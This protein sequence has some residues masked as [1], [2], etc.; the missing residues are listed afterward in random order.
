MS[1]ILITGANGQLGF[2]LRR[3]L[4]PLGEVFA[5]NREKFDLTNKAAMLAAL[6]ALR[7]QIVVNP[8]GY[9]AVDHAESEGPLAHAIN[10]HAPGVLA[11]WCAAND[12]LLIHYSTD[13][14]F[15]GTGNRAWT[16]DD[17]PEPMSVYANSKWR[18]EQTV[19]AH[20]GHHLILRTSWV[21]GSHGHNFLKTMLRLAA[22]RD[23]LSVVA[24]QI[25]APTS[26]ALIAD[27]TAQLITHYR[28]PSHRFEYGTYHLAAQGETSWHGYACHAIAHAQRL[29]YPL[30]LDPATIR[31]IDTEDYPLP[32]RR[33]LNSRLDCSKLQRTFSLTLP[34]WQAGVEHVIERMMHGLQ[35]KQ[36]P[37]YPALNPPMPPPLQGESGTQ[38][39]LLYN[40]RLPLGEG[41]A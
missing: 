9:T 4:A 21:Y 36:H 16:E 35:Y 29:G 17:T 28:R 10:A 41:G 15:S 32:A 22:E 26:A 24:D 12:A 37:P 27:V 34:P 5:V 3:A 31:A 6:D 2:E 33:P 14:I 8:A 39:A 23:H 20:T 13:Y 7:P 40:T 38:I 11:R 30:R 1:R 18:G 19:R 25:G